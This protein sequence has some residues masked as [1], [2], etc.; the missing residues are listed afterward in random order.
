MTKIPA[1]TKFVGIGAN[2]P[3]PENK[4]SQNNAFQEVY[5]IDDVLSYNNATSGLTADNYQDAID[6]LVANPYTGYTET[7]VNIPSSASGTITYSDGRP[8]ATGGILGMGAT[9][10]TLLAAPEV[11]Q[12]YEIEKIILEYT[13][14]TATYTPELIYIANQNEYYL[15]DS[16]LISSVA[17]AWT[18]SIGI[19]KVINDG[20]GDNVA[21]AKG[22]S[23][24]GSLSIGTWSGTNPTD[25]NGTL[26][27]IIIYRVRKFG[28]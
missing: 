21:V 5:T 2:V 8:N 9:P 22:S 19:Y 28:A 4:S 12:Y 16:N 20:F 24:S 6:K 7:I 23:L 17:N 10:I 11:G 14:G 15:I 3:T 18:K 13:Y 1:G 25:G 27:A 26:R